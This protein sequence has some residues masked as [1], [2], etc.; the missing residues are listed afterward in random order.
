MAVS[1]AVANA[2]RIA[3][4]VGG[5]VHTGEIRSVVPGRTDRLKV[6]IPNGGYVIPA[7]IVSSLGEGNTDAGFAVLKDMLGLQRFAR[8]GVAARSY[9]DAV[10]AVVAGGEY[11]IEPEVVRALGKGDMDA[12]HALLDKF[13]MEQRRRAVKRLKKLPPPAKG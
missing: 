1:R 6:H 2:L 13:V 4:A 9:E 10:P 5:K 8:G 7:D 3:R 12:G 11:V